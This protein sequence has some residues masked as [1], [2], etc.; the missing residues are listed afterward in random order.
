M[1]PLRQSGFSWDCNTT[2]RKLKPEELL[3][4]AKDCKALVAGTENLMPLIEV[5][6]SLKMISRVGIGLDGV[7]LHECRRRGIRVSWTPDALT[8]AVAELTVGLMINSTRFVRFLDEE[9]R[10]QDWS[11]PAGRGIG[12]SVIGLLGF[13]RI[14]STVASL[15][16]SFQPK[17]VLVYDITDKLEEISNFRKKGLSIRSASLEEAV[18]SSHILS[19]HLPLWKATRHLIGEQELSMMPEDSVLINT[20][21][22]GIVDEEAL[23]LALKH[24]KILGA[25]IDVFENEPYSGSLTSLSNCLL[26]SHIGSCTYSCR[27]RMEQ[28]ALSDSLRWLRGEPLEQEIPQEQYSYQK[29]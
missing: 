27:V 28:E 3:V 10:N 14:G 1:D 25:A 29:A 19:L 12:E 20:A 2:G 26:T 9:I 13:G 4:A 7:P 21:R 11:R 18:R 23:E 5:N 17:Q 16:S 8:Q 6:P 15:L 22:G 24:Q